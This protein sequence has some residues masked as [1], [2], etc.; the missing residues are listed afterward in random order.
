MQLDLA[1][2]HTWSGTLS[3]SRNIETLTCIV[4]LLFWEVCLPHS[5]N[6]FNFNTDISI[7]NLFSGG[8][9]NWQMHLGAAAT[10][11]PSLVQ[12]RITSKTP[13]RGSSHEK[14]QQDERVLPIEDKSAIRFLLGSFISI[15]I[16]SCTST[17]SGP[18]LGRDHIVM[19]ESAGIHL[20]NLTGCR[21]WVMAIIFEVS[22][23]DK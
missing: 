11:V 20:E 12:A 4:Q 5:N 21:N 8:R 15:D 9:Q 23:L 14:R 16:I 13:S 10:L 18:F 19:L 6:A 1:Q 3:L 2:S 17:R 22:L 7:Q